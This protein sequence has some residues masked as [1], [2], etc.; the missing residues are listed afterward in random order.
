MARTKFSPKR[1]EISNTVHRE[2]RD[3]IYPYIYLGVKKED[4]SYD[5]EE[6]ISEEVRKYHDYQEAR[7]CTLWIKH[8]NWQHD[9]KYTSQYRFRE[10]ERYQRNQDVSISISNNA[11]GHP[12][13]LSKLLAALFVYG[14]YIEA[15]L[16]LI[17]VVVVDCLRMRNGILDGTIKYEVKPNYWTK[18]TVIY[19]KFDELKKHGCI[20]LHWKEING[21]RQVLYR[22]Y[23]RQVNPHVSPAEGMKR[24][25]Q[26][27]YGTKG[28]PRRITLTAKEI[29]IIS[30]MPNGWED[31]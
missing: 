22:K 8:P 14:Y 23:G 5:D 15:T 30:E 11:S 29:E 16:R 7:D 24:A 31:D 18:Q 17:E 20:L 4:I 13:E 3:Y 10:A 25:E 1:L 27:V 9:M 26:S 28:Q 6:D 21:T 2:Y 12:G 19:V